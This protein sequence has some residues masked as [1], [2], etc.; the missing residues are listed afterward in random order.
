[1]RSSALVLL[2]LVFVATTVRAET[3]N[4]FVTLS[5]REIHQYS[6]TGA[7]LGTFL[8]A[9]SGTIFSGVAFDS[10]GNLYVGDPS[11]N[12]IRK[13]SSTGTDLGVFA[14]TGLNQPAGMRFDSGGNL[15]V[16]NLNG[17]NV[18]K[19][20]PTGVD[21][22]IVASVPNESLRDVAFDQD[23]NGYV[24]GVGAI[25]K[26]SPTGADLGQFSFIGPLIEG[27]EFGPNGHLFVAGHLGPIYELDSTGQN[28]NT[29][30]SI[31]F[32]AMGIAFDS[33]GNLYVARQAHMPGIDSSIE[34]F[35]PTGQ[36]LGAVGQTSLVPVWM[37]FAPVPE[38]ST[39]ALFALG[40]I[41]SSVRYARRAKT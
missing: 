19:F 15:Y 29:F 18:R 10:T 4:L 21:L 23:G 5:A 24:A 36:S 38:P 11:L 13:F 6:P 14:N 8:T 2:G 12:R 35:G 28:I 17:A 20:S 25:W 30:A 7:D 3:G 32:G 1:M 31:D 41:L 16:A 39:A 37:A 27:I 26:F 22:G 34:K 9:E 33:S 40:A